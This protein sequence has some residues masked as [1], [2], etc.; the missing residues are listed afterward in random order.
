MPQF[1]L[2]LSGDHLRG[3]EMKAQGLDAAIIAKTLGIRRASAHR[4]LA[5]V[6][7]GSRGTELW[8][9]YLLAAPS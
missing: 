6:I 5:R 9:R 2:P 8:R 3:R 4:A 1:D 7:D